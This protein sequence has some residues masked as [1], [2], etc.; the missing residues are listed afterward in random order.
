MREQR[1]L[2]LSP[3]TAP[4]VILQPQK[5][6]ALQCPGYTPDVDGVGYVPE[7]EISGGT[8]CEA[9]ERFGREVVQA[10]STRLRIP[11][12]LRSRARPPRNSKCS[13]TRMRWVN[14]QVGWP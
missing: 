8:G 1:Y 2:V 3:A 12:Q 11:L 5:N 4:I 6:P 7:M 10:S 14:S 13:S 9:G